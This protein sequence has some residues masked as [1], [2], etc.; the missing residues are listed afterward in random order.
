[1]RRVDL[2]WLACLTIGAVVLGGVVHLFHRYQMTRIASAFLREARRAQTEKRTVDAIRYLRNY[3]KLAPNDVEGLALLGNELAD[4]GRIE[5]A[6]LTLEKVLRRE[7]KRADTRRTLV[8]LAMRLGR[9]PEA[10]ANLE[11]LQKQSPQ[12]GELWELK[13]RCQ[14]AQSEYNLA[15][16]T[17]KSAMTNVPERLECYVLLAS[18][19]YSKLNSPA[20][21]MTC[22]DQM[23]SNNPQ[24][25]HAYLNRGNW[26]MQLLDATNAAAEASGGSGERDPTVRAQKL[27]ALVADAERA[28]EL[29]PESADTLVFAARVALT[30]K[31]YDEARQYIQS[32]LQLHPSDPRFYMALADVEA[33]TSNATGA[34]DALRRGCTA[35]PNDRDLR[36]NLVNRLIDLEADAETSELIEQL[37]DA[38]HPSE[39]I[40]YLEARMLFRRGQWLE[41]IDRLDAIRPRLLEWPQLVKQVDFL[42]A[43]AYRETDAVDQQLVCFRRAIEL[44]PR[45][46]PARMGLAESLL[47]ANLVRQASEEYK[48]VFA[49]PDA[50]T[51]A[52]I[53][54][55]RSMT[56][57]IARET[58]AEQD[59]SKFDEVLNEVE[60]RS[61]QSPQVPI[62]RAEKLVVQ[63]RYDEANQLVAAVKEKNPGEI[64]LWIVQITLAQLG[65]KW[66]D[67]EQLLQAAEEHFPENLALRILKGRYLAQRYGIEA[68]AQLKSVSQPI[69]TWSKK[70]MFQ[71]SRNFAALFLAIGDYDEAERMGMLATAAQPGDLSSRLLLFDVA[72]RA[73]RPKLMEQVLQEVKDITG[74]GPIWHFGQAVHL[75]LLGVGVDKDQ[76]TIDQARFHLAKAKSR[77][78]DWLRIP[79]LSA[80]IERQQGNVFATTD[81]L[82]EAI[83]LGERN[84][85]IL[86]E[87]VSLLFGQK[88]F[89]EADQVVR[90]MQ[91]RQ[92]LFTSEM[93]RSASEISL[94]LDDSARALDLA[95]QLVRRSDKNSDKVWLAQVLGTLGKYQEAEQQLRQLVEADGSASEPWVALVQI[96]TRAGQ[97]DK[98]EQAVAEAERAM[99]ADQ[100]PLAIAQCYEL[101]GKVDLARSRYQ[102]ALEQSPNNILVLRPVVEFQM[103]NG[104]SSEAE[105]L[106]RNFLKSSI[107]AGDRER[108]W[109]TRNLALALAINGRPQ[110][111][112]EALDLIER[113]LATG[114][115][116]SVDERVKALILARQPSSEQ[117]QEAIRIFE[118]LL[119]HISDV[120]TDDQFLLARL[121]QATG[122][123][124]KARAEFRKLLATQ[125]KDSR[126][127]IA[128]LQLLLQNG[129]TAEAELWLERLQA[130]AP[131][132]L[133]TADFQVHLSFAKGRYPEVVTFL[134]EV[135]SRSAR[136]K[137]NPESPLTRQLWGARRFEEFARKLRESKKVDEAARFTADSELLYQQYVQQRPT[138]VLTLAEFFAR[139]NQVE[140]ALELL[141][142]HWSDSAPERIAAVSVAVMEN[143]QSTAQ[144]L[145]RLQ[146]LLEAAN[147][148][149]GQTVVLS[150]VLADL[151]S[152]RG[153][154]DGAIKL[155]HEVLRRDRQNIAAM[156]N[157]AALLV[158]SGRDLMEA[159]RL[160]KQAIDNGGPRDV[161]LDTRG[162]AHLAT[163]APAK[164]L[165]DFEE[166]LRVS[167]SSERH[168]HVALAYAQLKQTE[169][170]KR[171]LRRAL[172]LGLADQMLHPLER[173]WLAD[174][175]TALGK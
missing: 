29:A 63:G 14:I 31:N 79:L 117:R 146:K 49:L 28:R 4:I 60:R 71:F 82:L 106:L 73:Q 113:N 76:K 23:V 3:V 115:E 83:S 62:L 95:E 139:V 41:A 53:E 51:A 97:R 108:R 34:L 167:G 111:L 161:L 173:P 88:R 54:L 151:M 70:E 22:L 127:I 121:Y 112:N 93:I 67:L 24:N 65:R 8:E 140:H 21:A 78:P 45:W 52:G 75:V 56:R 123:Q 170:A 142:E 9:Y 7:P 171:S 43:L 47:S 118:R 39:L 64:D 66:E 168:F 174:L 135:V 159:F 30:V 44:D 122:D 50:P 35:V 147:K 131:D 20:Q 102:A 157:L 11:E 74:E 133:V 156:N 175:R 17:L 98:A 120:S 87:T 103:R 33:A 129:E 143:H 55:A 37:R 46:I 5:P 16:E 145:V 99:A 114:P 154:Y 126:Y 104:R 100:A 148:E 164:A 92:N 80:E 128:Y 57:L 130:L 134:K 90:R 150:L 85:T 12:D 152:W 38:G 124:S 158:M 144:Q 13:G 84:P 110:P 153:E 96:L 19:L 101:L 160:I 89:I 94:R 15:K 155:Y 107:D 136:E 42:L 77:R 138:E 58:S 116:S 26:R 6:Y 91:E 1:M 27:A 40:G 172:E 25:S 18:L 119:A 125:S 32:G 137:D 10:L 166:S 2:R 61:P 149:P 169:A 105:L 132:D 68:S 81:Q 48:R 109:A 165:A 141:F 162:M 36:W 86:S 163:A 59:W 69:P 72:L